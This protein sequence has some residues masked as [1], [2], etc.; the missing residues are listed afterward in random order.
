MESSPAPRSPRTLIVSLVVLALVGAGVFFWWRQTRAPG[1][2][3][4]TAFLNQAVGGDRVLFS[5]EK[6]EALARG[7]AGWKMLVAAKARTIEPLYS[8]IDSS[9]YLAK[10]IRLDPATLSEARRLLA[11]PDAAAQPDSS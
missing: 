7:E 1:A 6:L 5:V 3:G 10:N 2:D 11:K 4:V 8:K 9:E